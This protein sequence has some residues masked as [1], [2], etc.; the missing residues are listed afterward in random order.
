[1]VT[2]YHSSSPPSLD[3]DGLTADV[4]STESLGAAQNVRAADGVRRRSDINRAKAL[5]SPGIGDP[6]EYELAVIEEQSPLHKHDQTAATT[7]AIHVSGTEAIHC[8]D[9]DGPHKDAEIAPSLPSSLT[10]SIRGAEEVA[11][12]TTLMQ[13]LQKKEQERKIYTYCGALYLCAF[14]IGWNDGTTGPLLP[15]IQSFYHVSAAQFS[16]FFLY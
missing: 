9:A 8:M 1:M 6:M 13:T 16:K 3:L 11:S 5:T 7:S 4:L 2:T 10:P 15:R 12:A 14:F